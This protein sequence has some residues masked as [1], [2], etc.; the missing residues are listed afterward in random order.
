MCASSTQS[1]PKRSRPPAFTPAPLRTRRDGWLAEVQC[2]FLGE[3]YLTGSV[4][5]A[6]RAV[7]RSRA[8]AYALRRRKG[9]ESFASA[10]DQVLSGENAKAPKTNWRKLTLCDLSWRVEAG[11]LRPLIYRGKVCGMAK[12][13][14]NSALLRLIRRYDAAVLRAKSGSGGG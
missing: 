9:A 14:D 11:L 7:G 8:S 2:R 13:P 4:A 6:A 3:L 12:K 1:R 5:R 10:W